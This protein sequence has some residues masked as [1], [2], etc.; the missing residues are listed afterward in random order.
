MFPNA[1][2]VLVAGL[3]GFYSF[4][5][6]I[7]LSLLCQFRRSIQ[8]CNRSFSQSIQGSA[9]KVSRLVFLSGCMLD[10]L[11]TG[12]LNT[13]QLVNGGMNL[14]ERS[15]QYSAPI[16]AF[17]SIASYLETSKGGQQQQRLLTPFASR[18]LV[19]VF[20]YWQSP[21]SGLCAGRWSLCWFYSAGLYQG[22]SRGHACLS[23]EP[24]LP[25]GLSFLS[26]GYW[27]G[28][29]VQKKQKLSQPAGHP[30]IALEN[31]KIMPQKDWHNQLW[32]LMLE[33]LTDGNLPSLCSVSSGRVLTC[34]VFFA[35]QSVSSWK[36][37]SAGSF[38][39]GLSSSW[40]CSAGLYHDSSRGYAVILLDRCFSVAGCLVGGP[41]LAIEEKLSGWWPVKAN[42]YMPGKVLGLEWAS[43]PGGVNQIGARVSLIAEYRQG[44][45]NLNLSGQLLDKNLNPQSVDQVMVAGQ[46][47]CSVLVLLSTCMLDPRAAL[48]LA[49]SLTGPIKILNSCQCQC[50]GDKKSELVEEDKS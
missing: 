28:Q 11:L 39:G 7:R 14:Q 33:S 20:S 40:S 9:S 1:A 13:A 46:Q 26:N 31:Q 42:N 24:Q 16:Q 38:A 37:P 44:L 35:C 32:C 43:G 27:E 15:I 10:E 50:Q 2:D 21:S 34:L 19:E 3:Q 47:N 5:S 6:F 12:K 48:V 17:D 23:I 30:G 25:V 18:Q 22:S 36:S 41:V 29:M 49:L 4:V 45:H 8:G